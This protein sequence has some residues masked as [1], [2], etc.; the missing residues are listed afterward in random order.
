V[1]TCAHV[2]QSLLHDSA[3]PDHL[4]SFFIQLTTEPGDVVLDPFAGSGT[5]LVAAK[6]LGRRWVGY[7]VRRSAYHAA[8]S[9]IEHESETGHRPE[10]SCSG[11]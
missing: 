3:H 8:M 5:T 4:A 9:R 10:V 11:G 7:E 2:S 6:R 1:L